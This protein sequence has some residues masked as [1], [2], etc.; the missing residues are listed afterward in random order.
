M[1]NHIRKKYNADRVILIA[2]SI[3]ILG[4]FLMPFSKQHYQIFLI[5]IVIS[6][7]WIIFTLKFNYRSLISSKI[8]MAS[9][10]YALFF[11]IS[12]SWSNLDTL[13]GKFKEVKTFLYLIFFSLVFLYSIDGKTQRLINLIHYLIV[14][15]VLSLFINFYFFYGINNEP[16]S[17]RFSGLGRLWNPLWAAAMYGG[18]AL[19]TLSILF[20]KYSQLKTSIKYALILSYFLL[21]IAVFLT[22]SRAP[23]GAVILMSFIVFFFSAISVKTKFILAI[24]I[25]ILGVLLITYFLP[26]IAEL[27]LER[28]Q[29]YRL[30]LWL[31]FFERAKE[32]LIFGHGG[33]S[34]VPINAPGEFVHEWRHY[35]STYVGSLVEMGL[36]G[37]ILHLT[38]IVTVLRTAWNLRS[39]FYVKTSAW[40]FIYTCII[41]LTFGHGILTRMNT[42]WLLFWM[43]L[44]VIAMYEIRNNKLSVKNDSLI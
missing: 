32:H 4:F 30:D 22:Q 20:D 15:A 28:G 14:A 23:I 25:S 31:G 7:F 38:I 3:W 43:P 1:F 8:I 18:A 19:I 39:N 34:N 6:A 26:V 41:G 16:I 9:F 35:H 40:L 12:I 10:A 2:M 13:S 17:S 5:T 24:V 44:L 11:L 42:Q 36:I 21:V 37:L 29:S 27:T 33:G